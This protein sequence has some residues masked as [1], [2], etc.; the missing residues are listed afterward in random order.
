MWKYLTEISNPCLPSTLI[1]FFWKRSQYCSSCIVVRI[2]QGSYHVYPPPPHIAHLNLYAPLTHEVSHSCSDHIPCTCITGYWILPS[3]FCWYLSPTSLKIM[4]PIPIFLY[5]GRNTVP[6]T[7][8]VLTS[9]RLMNW[10][11]SRNYVIQGSSL[12]Y[13]LGY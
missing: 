1:T 12:S 13:C 10:Y 7:Y 11:R 5:K 9:H 6:I 4:T 8:N 2:N 3:G